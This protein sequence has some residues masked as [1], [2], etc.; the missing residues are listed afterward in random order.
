MS[1][2][3]GILKGEVCNRDGCTGII[4]EHEKEGSCSCHI[5]PPCGY[6]ETDSAYCPS[7]GYE[8]REEQIQSYSIS[9][10]QQESYNRQLKEWEDQRNAF[11]TLYRS[12]EPAKELSMRTESHTHFS[13]KVVGVFPPG[14]D[15]GIIREKAKGTFGGRFTRFD[16]EIGRFEFIAYTD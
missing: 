7:C 3:E 1:Q 6:C 4:D 11:Y 13:Q 2:E 14:L 15:A 8:G 16:S 12:R 9:K 5:N 10:E